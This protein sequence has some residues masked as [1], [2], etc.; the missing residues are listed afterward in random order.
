MYVRFC[1]VF[2]VRQSDIKTT[3][4]LQFDMGIMF[5]Q[6]DKQQ[7]QK[8]IKNRTVWARLKAG[9]TLEDFK[10]DVHPRMVEG[11]GPI[12]GLSQTIFCPKILYCVVSLR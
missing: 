3:E 10:A 12:R 1:R 6:C 5:V 11:C 7:S 2:T 4:I 8:T 9:R